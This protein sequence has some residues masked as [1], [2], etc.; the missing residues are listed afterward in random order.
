MQHAG[1]MLRAPVQKL[2]P[3]STVTNLASSLSD[4]K[5][6]QK[7]LVRSLSDRKGGQKDLAS[8]LSDRKGGQE[9][10]VSCVNERLSTRMVFRFCNCEQNV[11]ICRLY[12]LICILNRFIMYVTIPFCKWRCDYEYE[13]A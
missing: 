7:D 8:S 12:Q 11:H 6:G 2:V 1:G 13:S 10:M 5:G 3:Y 4:R 9:D